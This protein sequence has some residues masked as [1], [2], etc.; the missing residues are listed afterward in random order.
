[1][2]TS[3]DDRSLV[4][5]PS[6]TQARSELGANFVRILGYFR[7]DGLKSVD[8]I[9]AAMRARSAA[10]LVVPAHTLKGESRQFGADPL[11]DLAE[12]IEVAARDCVERHDAP[13]FILEQVVQLR[14]LFEKTLT[15]LEREANPLVMRKPGGG[16]GRRVA[17]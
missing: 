4:N 11:A 8:A 13:D 1:M 12:T 5:W 15:L 14:P 17:V 9:E 3:V 10:G 2:T 7:E 16:F 6:Y